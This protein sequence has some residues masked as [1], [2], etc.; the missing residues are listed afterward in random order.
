MQ[1]D[2]LVNCDSRGTVQRLTDSGSGGPFAPNWIVKL[3]YH[4]L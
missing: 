2:P 1:L 3:E 4:N